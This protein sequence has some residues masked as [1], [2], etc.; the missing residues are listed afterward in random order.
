MSENRKL[1]FDFTLQ[2]RLDSG[3]DLEPTSNFVPREPVT[4]MQAK[5]LKEYKVIIAREVTEQDL[6]DDSEVVELP[7]LFIRLVP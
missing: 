6:S 7:H 5:G 3:V 1:S 2:L 4:I